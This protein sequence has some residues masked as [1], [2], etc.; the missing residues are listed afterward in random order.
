MLNFKKIRYK[1]LIPVTIIIILMAFTLTYVSINQSTSNIKKE[2]KD[3]LTSMSGSYANNFNTTL[4]SIES[5]ANSIHSLVKSTFDFNKLKS[6]KN[7]MKNYKEQI[8]PT[9]K[10]ISENTD[11]ILGAYVFFNPEVIKEA[12]DIYYADENNSGNFVKQKELNKKAYTRDSE[13]MSWFY[14]PYDKKHAIWTDTFYWESLDLNMFSFA[15]AIIING[16]HVGTIG[17]DIKFNQIK[18][19]IDKINPYETGYAFLLNNNQNFI[20]HPEFNKE[21]SINDLGI[22]NF[23]NIVQKNNNGI[24]KYTYKN[25]NSY[26]GYKKLTNGWTLGI[27]VPTNE[28]LAGVNQ[29]RNYLLIISII[30]VIIS[31]SIILYLGN[32]IAKPI[33]TL[34]EKI[35]KFGN[36]DLTVSFTQETNDEVGR[37]AKSLQNMGNNLR[38]MMKNIT[39][40]ASDLSA[41]SEELSASSEE[42]SASAQQVGTAIQEVASGAEE[43]SAQVDDTRSNVDELAQQIDNVEDMSTDM[44][45]QAD[46][47]MENI[48][49]GNNSVETSMSRVNKVS[50]KTEQISQKIDSLGNLSQEI[51]NIIELI[52]GISEQTNLLALNAAIEAAR[53]G[54]AGRGFSVVADEIRE[55]AEES[56]DATEQ[57]GDLIGEIQNGVEDAVEQMNGAEEVVEDSVEAIKITDDSFDEI[58]EAASNLRTLIEDISSRAQQMAANSQEVS[59]AV[60]EI[61]S[62]S[63]E[64]SSNAEEVA[65]SSEEQ[66][67]STQ[68][69]V[70]SSEEL[71]EMAEELSETVEQFEL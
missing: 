57:I 11:G 35:D 53:A 22:S 4:K 1:I 59:G 69:I 51:G 41:S 46:Q 24:I 56:S 65:A 6:N 9:I 54:E 18:S 15:K 30:A 43:Q 67:S 38:N 26:L 13:S 37:M 27:T 19:K 3:K 14:K 66:A 70:D 45:K 58:N 36:G 62:V 2:S 49:E 29:S 71:A 21:N 20:V 5:K 33:I 64:A 23:E 39:E 32:M 68:E 48:E 52:N 60:E 63:E 31:I 50:Q 28:V 40:V 7:Y 12:H 47:V 17:I 8:S 16:K 34:S 10:K 25:S 55:L 42:I 44:D 61:A